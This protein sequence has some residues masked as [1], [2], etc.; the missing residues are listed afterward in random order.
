MVIIQK[1]KEVS[2]IIL[3][4]SCVL[5]SIGQAKF[6]VDSKSGVILNKTPFFP[7]STFFKHTNE[8]LHTG[9]I[10][11]VLG[12]TKVMKEDQEQSQAFHWYNVQKEDGNKGWVYG[13]ALA[14]PLPPRMLDDSLR[15][16]N[17]KREEI[18]GDLY[19]VWFAQIKGKDLP[20]SKNKL[21][22][23]YS[24]MYLVFTNSVKKSFWVNIFNEGVQGKENT[25]S[26]SIKNVLGKN[27]KGLVLSKTNK[28]RGRAEL[29]LGLEIYSLSN[30]GAAKVLEEPLG[31]FLPSEIPSPLQ[32][33]NAD[34]ESGMIR[35]SWL[36]RDPESNKNGV[37]FATN[38]YSWNKQDGVFKLLYPTSFVQVEVYANE[39]QLP[40]YDSIESENI[41]GA[42][43]KGETLII[44]DIQE[45]GFSNEKTFRIQ[46]RNKSNQQ[47]WVE[48]KKVLF[49]FDDTEKL[50]KNA[51]QSI[52]AERT[53][54]AVEEY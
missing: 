17:G 30:M 34:I 11:K 36:E 5:S 41:K 9:D 53:Q 33:K 44:E 29:N 31:S 6:S 25:L 22:Y 8:V 21:S 50:F 13:D 42:F 52:G 32:V 15:K 24:E 23:D 46:C 19:N 51:Y 10:V 2:L 45:E 27:Q 35:F 7:D 1:I 3:F 40:F 16:W 28:V 14:L 12:Q 18:N 26:I 54:I 48:L 39:V 20:D 43:K 47:G 4:W 37:W 38:T 49:R